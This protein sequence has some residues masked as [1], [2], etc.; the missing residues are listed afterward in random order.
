MTLIAESVDNCGDHYAVGDLT[1]V[2][3]LSGTAE[4]VVAGRVEGGALR[5]N[6]GTI[7]TPNE[8]TRSCP[9]T[10]D[11]TWHCG[12]MVEAAPGGDTVLVRFYEASTLHVDV[13]VTSAMTIRVTRNGTSL[14]L[15]TTALTAGVWYQFAIH[16]EI[17]D[18]PNG[19]IHTWI[20]GVSDISATGLDTRNGGTG[21]CD[22]YMIRGEFGF[23]VRYDDIHAWTGN[24]NKG[25]SRVPG[26]LPAADGT[27]SDW[28]PSS[29]MDHYAMVDDP[30]PDGDLTTVSSGT[31]SQ[32][33]SYTMVPLGVDPSSTIHGV[34][35]KAISRRIDIGPRLL[36]LFTRTN[37]TDFDGADVTPPFGYATQVEGYEDNPDTTSPWTVSEVDGAEVG[38]LDNT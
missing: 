13:R 32:R 4:S 19:E 22:R 11:F 2:G 26:R 25:N 17:A 31:T 10:N 6:G 15:G 18:S 8:V 5:L 20:D 29:G 27:Y 3:W 38:I 34:V 7:I 21:V 35:L 14:A 23:S 30:V 37:S 36:A 9:L 1:M 28:T 33:D 12:I 24:D 16:A